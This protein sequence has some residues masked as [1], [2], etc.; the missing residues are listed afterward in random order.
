MVAHSGMSYANTPEEYEGFRQSRLA[1][2]AKDTPSRRL[3]DAQ[4]GY[5]GEL[6]LAFVKA[7]IA[8]GGLV[9]FRARCKAS[10]NP[11]AIYLDTCAELGVKAADPDQ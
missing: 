11:H 9:Y 5:N 10:S 2:E 8:S 4:N 3:R 6:R 7:L 1:R